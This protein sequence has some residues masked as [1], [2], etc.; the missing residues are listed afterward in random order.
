MGTLFDQI[1]SLARAFGHAS[2]AEP[3]RTA[4]SA[5][6]RQPAVV[7]AEG[8]FTTGRGK[9]AHGLVRGT[10]RFEIRA[11]VDSTCAGA[12][13]GIL[14]DGRPVG[15]PVTTDVVGARVLAGPRRPAAI[16]GVAPHGGRLT[17]ELRAHLVRALECGFDLVSGLHDFLCDDPVIAALAERQGA[18]LTDVR[19]PPTDRPLRFW[20]GEVADLRATR[21][22]VLGTDCMVGKRTTARLL[23]EGLCA[24]GTSAEMIH[25]GQTG[26]MQG[27]RYGIVL[28]SLPN[29]FVP[30]ELEGAMLRCAAEAAPDVMV[31]EGQ[32]G[33]RNPS[34]PGGGAV[35]ML[36]GDLHG[37]V[38]QHCPA[39][40][41]YDG[42]EDRGHRIPDLADEVELLERFGTPVCAVT[43]ST[44]G[45]DPAR[46]D[47]ECVRLERR[48]GRPVV[49]PLEHGVDRVVRAVRRVS[50]DRP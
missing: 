23:V 49:A 5:T 40:E 42:L 7:L 2:A 31:L 25:T 46:V 3:S 44:Q 14:L 4:T 10:S 20:T 41:Y 39:R 38:L 8:A 26:W 50:A 16:L 27:G 24:A 9:V 47:A 45:M 6:C 15:I 11:V 21:I 33:M 22:A 34:G 13:A 19:K 30:G 12:D 1:P 18:T 28:D 37:V 17:P 36:S 43:L 32:S 29:D 48:L 35:L